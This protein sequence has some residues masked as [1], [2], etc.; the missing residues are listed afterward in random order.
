MPEPIPN[1]VLFANRRTWTFDSWRSVYT[2]CDG[3]TISTQQL[4]AAENGDEIA[5]QLDEHIRGRL[6]AADFAAVDVC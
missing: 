2:S 3:W 5:A 4:A 6:S 1:I